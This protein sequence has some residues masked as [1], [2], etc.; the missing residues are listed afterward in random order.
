MAAHQYRPSDPPLPGGGGFSV[1]A[2]PL[3]FVPSSFAAQDVGVQPPPAAYGAPGGSSFAYP[4][5]TGAYG[6][7]SFAVPAHYGRQAGAGFAASANFEDEPPLL[8]G[9]SCV[10]AA[11]R[12]RMLTRA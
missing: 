8:E 9:A 5:P 6:G 7:A 11:A 4:P 2:P 12:A 10:A 3:A 1:P